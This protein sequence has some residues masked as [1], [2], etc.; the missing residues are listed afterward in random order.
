MK[1]GLDL[2]GSW[3]ELLLL[4]RLR[5]L[6]AERAV[7]EVGLVLGQAGPLSTFKLGGWR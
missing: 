2:P 1:A 4:M 7:A 6:E 5:R 3:R